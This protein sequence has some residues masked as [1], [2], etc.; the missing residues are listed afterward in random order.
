MEFSICR[1]TLVLNGGNTAGIFNENVM[2][3]IGEAKHVQRDLCCDEP[4]SAHEFLLMLFVK[5]FHGSGSLQ[6][7]LPGE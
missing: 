7:E 1:E 3:V 6:A 2:A 5:R 4:F